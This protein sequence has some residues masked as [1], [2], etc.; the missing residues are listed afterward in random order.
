[1]R[2]LGRHVSV[3][4]VS[5]HLTLRTYTSSIDLGVEVRGRDVFLTNWLNRQSPI[6]WPMTPT[7]ARQ[8]A[9]RLLKAADQAE[10]EPQ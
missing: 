4:Y 5:G 7:E 6:S 8:Y 2:L 3:L 9:A 1:M 10:K